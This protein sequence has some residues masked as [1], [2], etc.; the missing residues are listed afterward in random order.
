MTPLKK[1]QGIPFH[2]RKSQL[3]FDE[4]FS[5]LD[6]DLT[7]PEV[8]ESARTVLEKLRKEGHSFTSFDR[9]EPD[10]LSCL[11]LALELAAELAHEPT[12]HPDCTH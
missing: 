9:D 12:L 7:D 8:E 2:S 3:L 10:C 6:A 11:Y 1:F 4:I 5:L